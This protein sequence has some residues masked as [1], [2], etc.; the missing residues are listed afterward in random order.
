MAAYLADS[1][2]LLD[3]FT[4]DP[5]W[6]EWSVGELERAS[7]DGIVFIDP[8]VYSE[9]SIR[10]SR[11]EDLEEAIWASVSGA[12]YRVRPSFSQARPTSRTAR[13]AGREQPLY[14]TSL[15]GR[16]RRSPGSC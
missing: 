16:T 13:Q 15:S 12:R 5:V 9:I 7:A 3:V 8:F 10:F 14:P 6:A 4:A 1:S 11:I 2:V